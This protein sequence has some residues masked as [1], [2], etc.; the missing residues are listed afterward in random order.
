M[1][2]SVLFLVTPEA[3]KVCLPKEQLCE[4]LFLAELLQLEEE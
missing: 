2:N 4:L 1:C 3:R